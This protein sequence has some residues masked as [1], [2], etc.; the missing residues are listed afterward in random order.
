MQKMMDNKIN[1]YVPQ[2][3]SIVSW[4]ASKNILKKWYLTYSLFYDLAI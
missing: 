2:I 1:G 4:F 3:Q